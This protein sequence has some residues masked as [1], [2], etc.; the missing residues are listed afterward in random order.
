[1]V[2][3]DGDI[4]KRKLTAEQLGEAEPVPQR[5]PSV[6]EGEEVKALIGEPINYLDGLAEAGEKRMRNL[7]AYLKSGAALSGAP[8]KGRTVLD[9]ATGKMGQAYIT[10]YGDETTDRQAAE[11]AAREYRAE[12]FAVSL[13]GRIKATREHIAEI[14]RKLDGRAKELMELHGRKDD[15]APWYLRMLEELKEADS[16]RRSGGNS[17][18]TAEDYPELAQDDMYQSLLLSLRRS[19]ETLQQLNNARDQH[20]NGGEHFWNDFW[21]GTLQGALDINKWDFGK[22]DLQEAKTVLE[23]ARKAERGEALT[24]AEQEAMEDMALANA[25]MSEFDLGKGYRW[26]DM[27]G[28]SLSFMKDFWITGGFSGLGGMTARGAGAAASRLAPK[29]AAKAAARLGKREVLSR[30]ARRGFLQFAKDEGMAGVGALLKEQSLPWAVKAL[31]TTADELLVRAPLMANTV[32]GMSTAAEIVNKKTGDAAYDQE[33]GRFTFEDGTTWSNAVWQVQADK[34]IENASEMWGAHL[35][36]LTGMAKA[37]GARKLTAALLKNTRENAGTVISKAAN[38]MRRT[39]MNGYVGEVLEEYDGQVWRTILGLDSAYDE[40]G[41]NLF[42]SGQFHGDIWGGM[43]LSV[44]L[45][46]GGAM[47]VGSGLKYGGKAVDYYLIRNAVNRSDRK[48]STALTAEVWD[49]MRMIID[50]TGNSDIG[51]LAEQVWGDRSMTDAQKT[52]VLD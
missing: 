28:S 8:M 3:L 26:G 18:Y 23:I 19:R 12:R 39:G 38:F 41:Q 36:G 5:M 35:P 21:R 46:G 15:T 9:P 45:T 50:C 20:D 40:N 47:A 10:P 14:E 44:G 30:V 22:R 2:F 13:P 6:T 16:G 52:A 33:T 34:A 37:F 1:M 25:V 27:A 31:G 7:S 17:G 48:A 29:W 43:A 51:A 49:P 11:M 32:Q 4:S 42:K 24:E